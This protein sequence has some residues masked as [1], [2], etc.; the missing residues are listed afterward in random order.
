MS[1]IQIFI[2]VMVIA[3]TT[4]LLRLFPFVLFGSGRQTPD[5]V[6]YLGKVF[7][8]AIMALLVVY[9]LKGITPFQ[10]PYGLPELLAAVSVVLLQLWKGNNLL[11]IL[12]GTIFYMLLVQKVFPV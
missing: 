1:T 2:M 12:A 11:S 10:Y 9:C 8:Y 3:A 4:F 5:A 6:L 7:P